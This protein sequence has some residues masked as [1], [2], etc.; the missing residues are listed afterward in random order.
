ML[1][2]MIVNQAYIC[3]KHIELNGILRNLWSLW[4][5]SF[6]FPSLTNQLVVG[7]AYDGHVVKWI[8]VSN[9]VDNYG[10]WRRQN[11]THLPAL[12]AHHSLSINT[13]PMP[14]PLTRRGWA[15]VGPKAYIHSMWWNEKH[16][17]YQ[18]EGLL[19]F[20]VCFIVLRLRYQFLYRFSF[21]SLIA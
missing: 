5:L 17:R 12:S 15:K 11:H 1:L 16:T 6:C 3:W 20:S 7:K 21:L 14:P 18:A 10:K 19:Y 9:F 2:S 8:P 4:Y 13:D